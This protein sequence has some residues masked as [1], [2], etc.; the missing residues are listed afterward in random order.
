MSRVVR[1]QGWLV[2]PRD[3]DARAAE[4]G[5]LIARARAA[6]RTRD[7]AAIAQVATRSAELNQGVLPMRGFEELRSMTATA[8]CLGLQI[9]HSGTVAGLLFHPAARRQVLEA[10]MPRVRS[11]GIAPLGILATAG[12]DRSR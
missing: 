7:L 11:L 2:T 3:E 12:D 4:Y 9:S 10:L 1:H 6:F 8:G 5:M